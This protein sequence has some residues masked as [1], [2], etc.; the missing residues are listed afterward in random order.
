MTEHEE[1]EDAL[2]P[3]TR[4]GSQGGAGQAQVA[5]MGRTGWLSVWWMVSD[6]I[7]SAMSR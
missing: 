2:T 4:G 7:A 5:G 1:T 6:S 3:A